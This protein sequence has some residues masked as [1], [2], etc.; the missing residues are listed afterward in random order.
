MPFSA[1]KMRTRREFGEA[2]DSNKVRS[3]FIVGSIQ[4]VSFIS[5]FADSAGSLNTR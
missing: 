3:V 1:R 2:F 5:G 4:I